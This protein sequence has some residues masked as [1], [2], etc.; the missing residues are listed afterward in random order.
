MRLSA[1]QTRA[2]RYFAEALPADRTVDSLVSRGLLELRSNDDWSFCPV[3]TP[4]GRRVLKEETER[5]LSS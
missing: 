4:A 5:D 3:I 2:L 1:A